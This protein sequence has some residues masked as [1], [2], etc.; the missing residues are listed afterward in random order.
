MRLS[1]RPGRRDRG[2]VLLLVMLII[3]VLAIVV[4]Q[5]AFSA[6]VAHRAASNLSRDLQN[7]AS[8][9]SGLHM[10]RLMI[11]AD[12]EG[13]LAEAPTP[14][15]DHSGE[16][17]LTEIA[18]IRFNE[19]LPDPTTLY[20]KI[21]D[22]EGKFYL[23]ALLDQA[24][25]VVE[26]QMDR[27]RRMLEYGQIGDADTADRIA[28]AMDAGD[29]GAFDVDVPNRKF[30]TI[31]ELLAVPG[32]TDDMY[33]GKTVDGVQIY[34]LADILTLY[35]SGRVN[36]NTATKPVLFSLSTGIAEADVDG[37]VS[38][39]EST[40]EEDN[41]E[42][43]QNTSY[44]ELSRSGMSEE[45]YNTVAGRMAVRSSWFRARMLARTGSVQRWASAVIQ[46]VN[47]TTQL[48][49]WEDDLRFAPDPEEMKKQEEA[50]KK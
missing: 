4:L 49:L 21:E 44:E 34:G 22:E 13:D 47:A 46:R 8:V 38:A 37:M 30:Y 19:D 27:L 48:I 35:G 43:F 16:A 31:K 14:P 40:D 39:R 11:K 6:Q 24:G 2:V 28:A 50:E 32:I 18:P 25:A 7:Q 20:L 1:P 26:D 23:P 12:L 15:L 42:V 45:T 33:Y 17:L 41:P 36:I 5:L 10:A 3:M 29:K 9:R